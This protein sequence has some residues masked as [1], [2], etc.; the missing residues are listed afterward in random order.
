MLETYIT[1]GPLMSAH[2]QYFSG[3][4]IERVI[5]P[6]SLAA[7]IVRGEG[8]EGVAG[9]FREGELGHLTQP[10]LKSCQ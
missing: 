6:W 3:L 1:R 8:V 2:D 7:A 9:D 10:S 5:S 4:K